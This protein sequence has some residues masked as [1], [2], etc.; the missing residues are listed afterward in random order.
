ME[1]A[2]GMTMTPPR[3]LLA[4][5][6]LLA[7]TAAPAH[8]QVL[9]RPT[10]YRV[11]PGTRFVRGCFA[12]C[13]CPVWESSSVTGTFRL[14]L[15]TVGDVFDFYE[16][17]DVH[18][19]VHR[20]TGEVL[21]ITGSGTYAVSTIADL[22]RM[23]LTLTVGT[24]PPTAYHADEVP[25]GAA[26]PK[27]AIHV[28]I[29]GEYCFDSLLDLKARPA[30]RLF[31]EPQVA[32]WDPEENASPAYDVVMG[33]LRAL[34]SSGGAFD[35]ATWGCVADSTPLTSAECW[36]TPPPGEGF[37]YLQR[38]AGGRYADD[39]AAQAG[40]PDPGIN[41]SPSACP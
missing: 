24:D 18:L 29:H 8:A 20:S 9:D 28:S 5:A 27:I 38:V 19:K 37:W 17:T 35:V 1:V 25:G 21:P 2:G 12:P 33:D 34:R 23:D 6:A 30:R 31:V 40:S 39:D 10:L 22:Q 7:L 13:A 41:A 16:V 36:A 26:F 3:Q 11:D 4:A 32:H 15:I 14:A